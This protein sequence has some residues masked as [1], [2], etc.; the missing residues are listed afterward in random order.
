ME[1]GGS[2]I[3]GGHSKIEGFAGEI[4]IV[5]VAIV[6]IVV[7][8]GAGRGS[9]R[10]NRWWNY[11]MI[12]QHGLSQDFT[13]KVRTPLLFKIGGINTCTNLSRAAIHG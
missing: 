7:V 6:V 1:L 9:G 4:V 2:K 12:H 3:L 8:G 5:A 11:M 10:S 13:K